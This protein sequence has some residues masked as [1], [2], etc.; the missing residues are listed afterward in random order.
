MYSTK[1]LKDSIGPAGVRLTTWE[2]C[3]PRFVH[4]ELM[5]HRVFSRNSASSRAI[6]V[7][8]MLERIENNPALPVFWG[9]NQKGMQASEELTGDALVNA[10]KIWDRLRR[11]ACAGVR[12]LQHPDID[13]HKQIANRALEPWMFITVIVSSTSFTNWFRLRHHKDA[14]PEIRWI[15]EDMLPKYMAS[16]PEV[17]KEGEWHLPM[18]E[19]REQLIEEGFSLE[20]LKAIS[21]G[22]IAR[23][24]YLTHDG[25]RDPKK[26]IELGLRLATQNPPHMS[27]LE[28]VAQAMTKDAWNKHVSDALMKAQRAGLPFNPMMLGN[29]TAWFQYRK[30]FQN[31]HGFDFDLKELG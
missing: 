21:A 26:D 3:Y 16:T 31:E 22:R 1:I 5:T 6:P 29:F 20:D 27:P 17:L 25:V 12:E 13:L 15:A 10:Q 18:L 11:N 28:H 30:E 14:Q 7:K 19:D 4:A 9:K 2:L 24:S 8:S 23:V